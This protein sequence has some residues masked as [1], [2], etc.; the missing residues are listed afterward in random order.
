MREDT[1]SNSGFFD[2]HITK[3]E[4]TDVPAVEPDFKSDVA[5][6]VEIE[7]T[8]RSG[9]LEP[10]ARQALV[11]LLKHG[12][13]LADQKT[14]LFD[15]IVKYNKEISHYLADIYLKLLV[16]ETTGV[17]LILQQKIT[18][19]EDHEEDIYSLVSRRTLSLYDTLLLLVLRKHFQDRQAIGETKI[20]IEISQVER[21]LVPFLPLT[22]STKRDRAQ[23]NGALKRMVE[24][25]IL[26]RVRGDD[27]RFEITQVIRYVVGADLLSQLLKEYQELAVN[28]DVALDQ[29]DVNEH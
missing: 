25:K 26:G 22:N 19:E 14:V 21:G 20:V 15:Y 24:R 8:G 17:A 11:Y 18:E 10:D 13:I 1:N 5:I 23:L 6:E 16:D 9:Y 29:G 4:K 12:V 3:L 27:D 2:Q 28:A 7:E